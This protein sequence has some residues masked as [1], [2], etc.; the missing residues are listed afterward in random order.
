MLILVNFLA[1]LNICSGW[2]VNVDPHTDECYYEKIDAGKKANLVFQ[3]TEGGFLDVD[4]T[5]FGP[6]K[7]LIY[8]GTRETNGK[9]T[10]AA[11]KTGHYQFC[12]S[13]QMSTLTPKSVQFDVSLGDSVD[14]Q[15]EDNSNTSIA[16]HSA[17][18]AKGLWGVYREQEYIITRMKMHHLINEHTN[19]V[20]MRW[21][22]FEVMLIV[23]VIG[24]EVWY[25]TRFFE[26][27]R[28]V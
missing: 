26:V 4:I 23:T 1:V 7:R 16:L 8:S 15:A 3:V 13:N 21:C 12:F 27:K 11:Y 22:L 24:F 28:V 9:F 6:D 20:V 19:T 17:E 5:I 14:W 2:L 10:F 18:L 25:I